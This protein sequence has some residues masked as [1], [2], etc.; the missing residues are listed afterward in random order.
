MPVRRLAPVPL[1][2]LMYRGSAIARL[3]GNNVRNFPDVFEEPVRMWVFEEEVRLDPARLHD[4][5]HMTCTA[6]KGHWC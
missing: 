4:A 2:Q 3:A 1:P 6:C 5:A